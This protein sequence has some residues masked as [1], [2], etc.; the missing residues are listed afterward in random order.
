M[1]YLNSTSILADT[2]YAYRPH[3]STEDAMLD[4]V[5]HVHKNMDDGLITSVT[6]IDLSKA[7]DSV[8]HDLLLK[9]LGWYGIP[10]HWF[11]SYLDQRRQKVRGG[12]GTLPVTHGVPQGS[13]V[14]PLLFSLFTNDLSNCIPHGK[15]I[16]YADDTQI[17]DECTP[18]TV[19]LA[20]L[21]TRAEE[22]IHALQTWFGRN[23]LKMNASKTDF[24]LIGTKASLRH[25]ADFRI[26][27]SESL[28]PPS[29]TIK[30]LGV[31][32]DRTLSWEHHI[33]K[34][35][36]KCFGSLVALNRFRH[37]FTPEA[38][39][40]IIQAHVLPHVGYCLPVWGGATKT[41]LGRV[42][43]AITLGLESSLALK[44][45][46]TSHQ[47]SKVLDGVRSKPSSQ[48]AIV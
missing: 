38:L 25:T 18:T 36:Q 32:I 7:F 12:S 11:G 3:H 24:I 10:P 8:G 48:N 13:L 47:L 34:V 31:V 21:K 40:L 5:N 26:Q 17:I 4:F 41:Q 2:Q 1:N 20:E 22:T 33:S 14:G 35:V 30:L 27:L 23:S 19:C 46:N 6:A 9:K 39:R 16:S 44:N 37:H 28:L 45:G 15:L 42:Q 29:K 43:K